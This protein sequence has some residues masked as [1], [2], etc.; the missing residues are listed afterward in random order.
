MQLRDIVPELFKPYSAAQCN[1]DD[2]THYV[3]YVI[4]ELIVLLFR[5]TFDNF[6]RELSSRELDYL[7]S[8]ITQDHR[9]GH[10][11]VAKSVSRSSLS[12]F[13]FG[14]NVSLS[15]SHCSQFSESDCSNILVFLLV[16]SNKGHKFFCS[17][18]LREN[19]KLLVIGLI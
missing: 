4:P 3:I 14:R 19:K 15:L 5:Y 7:M 13:A 9:Q 12:F 8:Q 1:F 11:L 18:P 2:T 16:Y 6:G 10:R 17:G